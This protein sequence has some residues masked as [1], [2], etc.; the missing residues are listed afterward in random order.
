[1]GRFGFLLCLLHFVLLGFMH[2]QEEPLEPDL[3]RPESESE[4][5][6]WLK[7]GKPEKFEHLPDR[8]KKAAGP[9]LKINLSDVVSSTLINQWKVQIAI[10]GVDKQCGL[11]LAARG[12]FDPNLGAAFK[13]TWM[14]DTQVFGFKSGRDGDIDTAR[15]FV[16]KLLRLG[17]RVSLEG[18]VNKEHNPSFLFGN[19]YNR[20]NATTLTFAIDQPLLRRFKY[21]EQSVDEMVNELEVEAL[22][23]ELIQT[24]ASNVR[25]S[26]FEYWDLVASKKVVTINENAE[27]I[28][29]GLASATERLVD[30]ER[31]AASELNQQFAELAR[32]NRELIASEQEVFR[33]FNRLLFEMGVNRCDFP[34]ESPQLQLE[35]FP[36]FKT[37]KC[38]WSFDHL[39]S[40][41]VHNRGDL[42]AAQTR[43]TE[44]EWLV[45]LA[46]QDIYPSLD[47]RLGYDFF[48]SQINQR[49]KPFFSSTEDRL[50]QK[51]YS[52]ELNLSFPLCNDKARG[53]RERRIDE[54]AQACLEENQLYEDILSR[55]ATAYRNQIELLDQI[56]Y[57][58]K[59]VVWYEKALQD[60]ILR[61]KEG[62]GS[63]FVV[64]DFENRLRRALIEQVSVHSGWAKNIV[65]LLFPT[66]MLIQKD[67]CSN[68]VQIEML[69]YEKLLRR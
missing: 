24:M 10:K 27:K 34:L 5:G 39:L 67:P 45:R 50:A 13:S 18:Q 53:E 62:Y 42:L 41:A 58:K 14:S 9:P 47:L 2:A 23:N 26:L 12:P 40:L 49:S 28:L 44:T 19:P 15:V 38:E 16:D 31:V 30:G 33:V 57:A 52:V 64:I 69:N 59:T 43:I 55:V 1:M 29:D 61:Y 48:N 8:E 7:F 4:I 20:T 68:Q 37:E 46:R 65:E 56:Y 11:A 3:T 22:Q 6:R 36:N 63:L 60:E 25:N 54:K 66:G 32:N 21:N 51:N 17:T 35:D